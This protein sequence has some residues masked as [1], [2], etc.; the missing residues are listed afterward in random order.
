M[1][2]AGLIEDRAFP[3]RNLYNNMLYA[4]EDDGSDNE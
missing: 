3:I 1:T 2:D 4:F